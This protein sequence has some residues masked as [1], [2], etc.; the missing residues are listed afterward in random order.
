MVETLKGRRKKTGDVLFDVHIH[1][2][3]LA[4]VV[5]C[6]ERGFLSLARNRAACTLP[7]ANRTARGR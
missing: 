4:I 6:D 5:L 2:L 3:L 7:D 1:L